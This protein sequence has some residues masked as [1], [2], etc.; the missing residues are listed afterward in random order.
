MEYSAGSR[1]YGILKVNDEV[2]NFQIV[3]K[4]FGKVMEKKATQQANAYYE[5]L[6]SLETAAKKGGIGIWTQNEN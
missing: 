3:E 6:Q 5:K 2:L 1:H 4:G